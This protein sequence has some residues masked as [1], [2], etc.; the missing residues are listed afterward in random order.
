VC[1]ASQRAD[2]LSSELLKIDAQNPDAQDLRYAARWLGRGAVIAIP[3][4]TLYALAADP[5]NLA[6]V[7]AIFRV[8]G[9]PETRA[10]PILINSLEQAMWL[11]RNLP[12]N[13]QKL[14]KVCWPGA[15]TLVVD[16]SNR[17]PLKVTANTKRIALRWPKSEVVRRLILEFGGPITGTSANISGSPSCSSGDEVFRQLGDRIPLILD[18]GD[19]G[20]IMPSTIVELHG[21]TWRVG[22]EGTISADEIKEALES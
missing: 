10:L 19:T 16:A 3:T 7:D 18:A 12:G 14:A 6:A 13:F 22:R 5:L 8:K 1:A 11:G 21:E 15:L 20:E 17:L 9:R 2:T 4:D